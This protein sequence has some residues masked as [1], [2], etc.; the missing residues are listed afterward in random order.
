LAWPALPAC[1][2]TLAM[3]TMRP[4]R[5]F[6]MWRRAARVAW[7]APVRFVRITSRQAWSD[8]RV[9]DDVGALRRETCTECA[10]DV[11]GPAGDDGSLAGRIDHGITSLGVAARRDGRVARTKGS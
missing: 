3:L 11:A 1:P 4:R 8:I 10:P 6:S 7:K 5:A 2:A 9:E